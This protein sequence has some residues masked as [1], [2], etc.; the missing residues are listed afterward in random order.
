[1]RERTIL[2]HQ[3][4][5][6]MIQ[7]TIKQIDELIAKDSFLIMDDEMDKALN[8]WNKLF[9]DSNKLEE[10]HEQEKLK[11]KNQKAAYG[12]LLK[13]EKISTT[14]AKGTVKETNKYTDK[15][16]EMALDIEFTKEETNILT[17]KYFLKLIPNKIKILEHKIN[18][19]K[20]IKST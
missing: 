6:T 1:M 20:K 9:D 2:D 7:E 13:E 18:R 3:V 14:D 10:I 8:L 5:Q 17:M 12:I 16:L 19:I 4:D 15:T 11:Y